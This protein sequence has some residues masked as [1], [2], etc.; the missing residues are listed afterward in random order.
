[1][2]WAQDKHGGIGQN[3][4]LPWYVPEDLKNFK[5]LENQSKSDVKIKTNFGT[6]TRGSARNFLRN[7]RA[8]WRD[9]REAI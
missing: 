7:A 5:N 2:I 8:C 6:Q 1:M 9:Y 3:G 4:K